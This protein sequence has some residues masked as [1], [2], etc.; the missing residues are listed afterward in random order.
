M[1]AGAWKRAIVV[2]LLALAMLACGSGAE[3]EFEAA[4]A[5]YQDAYDAAWVEGCSATEER[6]REDDP[7]R[8]DSPTFSSVGV[9]CDGPVDQMEFNS[10]VDP[11]VATEEGRRQG[12]FDGCAYVYDEI[13]GDAGEAA[14][15]SSYRGC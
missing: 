5:A 11:V 1:P 13:Y 6:I 12:E 7:E 9:Q 2:G 8:F 10:A 14:S 4:D 3:P 15:G